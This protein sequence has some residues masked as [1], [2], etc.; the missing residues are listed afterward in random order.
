MIPIGSNGETEVRHSYFDIDS[1]ERWSGATEVPE[2][3]EVDGALQTPLVASQISAIGAG[4]SAY[5][6]ATGANA[7]S[8]NRLTYVRAGPPVTGDDDPPVF[9]SCSTLGGGAQFGYPSI[10]ASPDEDWFMSAHLR[11]TSANTNRVLRI[12]S[13]PQDLCRSPDRVVNRDASGG[14]F[15]LPVPVAVDSGG[16]GHEVHFDAARQT[17]THF[18]WED[19][20]TLV[21]QITQST[22]LT[23]SDEAQATFEPPF[24]SLA[25]L[26]DKDAAP[27]IVVPWELGSEG[28]FY[29]TQ[30][31][32]GDW[33]SPDVVVPGP[34]G[35]AAQAFVDHDDLLHVVYS[36]PNG[37]E[38]KYFCRPLD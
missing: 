25:L 37:R 17:L 9:D 5:A 26:L 28:L 3:T 19:N 21:G 16:T 12:A 20:G 2:S 34:V 36:L 8:E 4:E 33:L 29:L 30:N 24:A 18:L 23:R 38:L 7:L 15:I 27:H 31:D 1:S 13:T 11:I 32:D 14:A 35:F 22:V 10:S 6:L